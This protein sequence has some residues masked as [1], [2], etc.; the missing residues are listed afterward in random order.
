MKI[1]YIYKLINEEVSK[2]DFLGMDNTSNEETREGILASKEFQTNL[3]IDII[4]NPEN[5]DKFKKISATFVNKDID[6]F[7]DLEIVELEI[8]MTYSFN[9]TDYDLIFFLDG[10]KDD[11]NIKYKDF[12]LNLFSKAGEKVKFDWIQKNEKLYE[13]LIEK[14]VTPF[15]K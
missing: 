1:K 11:D 2:F 9:E 13:T 3:V 14:I 15:I 12:N 7:N 6:R 8:D 4:N 10:D 5:R